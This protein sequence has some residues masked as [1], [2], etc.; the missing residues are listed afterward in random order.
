MAAFFFR[1][2]AILLT[3]HHSDHIGDLGE[4]AVQSWIAGRRQPL[5]VKG[6]EG[7]MEVAN[8]FATAYTL[9]AGF[10]ETHHDA[11]HMPPD[12]ARMIPELIPTP[13]LG[14]FVQVYDRDGLKISAFLIDHHSIEPAFGFRAE[15]GGRVAVVSGDTTPIPNMVFAATGADVLIHEALNRSMVEMIAR[16]LAITGDQRRSDMLTDTL[17]YHTSPGEAAEIARKAGVSL[18]VYNHIVPPLPNALARRMFMRE[19]KSIAGPVKTMIGD[20]GLLIHL[21]QGT[22]EIETKDLL[23][24]GA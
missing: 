21:P 2:I 16:A 22:K 6:P 5:D 3:H 13:A 23:C 18:L 7:T 1:R 9:D 15:Y 10:R 4:L 14:Q 12:A 8:G 17:D 19:V 24:P 20:D 11:C